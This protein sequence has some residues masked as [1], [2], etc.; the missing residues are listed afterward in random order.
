MTR[1]GRARPLLALRARWLL[2]LLLWLPAAAS[3][4]ELPPPPPGFEARR[5]LDPADYA[6]K[7]EG[8]Y[9]TG[10]P[11]VNYDTNTGLG[12]G[13]RGYYYLDGARS[14]PRFAYTP[15]LHRLF[16]QAFFTTRGMQYHWLDV[17]TRSILGTPYQFRGQFIFMRNIE[18]HYFGIGAR[19]RAPLSVSRSPQQFREFSAYQAE[20][21]RIDEQ[22]ETRS[23]YDQYRLLQPLALLSVERPFWGGRLRPMLGLGISYNQIHDYSAERISVASSGGRELRATMGATRLSEDCAAGLIVGCEGGWNNFLRLGLSFDTRDF[24]PD[25][26]HG[27]FV[28]AALDLGTA[29]VGSEYDWVRAMLTPRAYVSLL[30]DLADLVLAARATF[31]VQ[32]RSSP[33]FGMNLIPFTEE[34]RMGL[35]GLRTL[36][37]YKQDRFVGPVM[38]LV[39]AELR[40][41]FLRFAALGQ[42]FGVIAVPFIDL[43]SV[44]DRVGDLSLGG[45]KRDQGL[46]LRAAWN[47]ATIIAVEYAWSEEDAGFYVNFNHMF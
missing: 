21:D 32:S 38:T 31:Q 33:F 30:G 9:F 43:G 16:L 20:L 19:S 12:F 36:R 24:E 40:W 35:G 14:D 29:V 6:Q 4:Q 41:S 5:S 15:Y 25:P 17:D 13:A 39:N 44:Y 45:W 27:F 10:L 7:Q 34:P 37:G 47:L 26:N 2:A 8:G 3:A 22:G 1:V 23:R 46:A 28:D 18:Q 42:K 11:L